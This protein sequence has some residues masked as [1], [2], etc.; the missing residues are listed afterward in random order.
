MKGGV[1]GGVDAGVVV[2]ALWV[3][4]G[5]VRG[6]EIDQR[7]YGMGYGYGSCVVEGCREAARWD[8]RVDDEGKTGMEG[9]GGEG[10]LVGSIRAQGLSCRLIPPQ[11]DII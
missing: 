1:G 5:L 4:M 3:G 8:G 9:V 7:W 10:I 11:D 2:L 6:L